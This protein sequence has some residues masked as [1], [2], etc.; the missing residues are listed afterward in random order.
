MNK[1]DLNQFAGGVLL[2]KFNGALETVIKNMQDPN[3]SFKNKRGI[4]IDIG[5]T[6]NEQRDDAKVSIAVKTKL[7][8]VIPI[9]TSLFMGK[10]LETGEI[11]IHEYGKQ[12]PG[13]MNFVDIQKDTTEDQKES[14]V[15]NIKNIRN[16]RSAKTN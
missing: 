5:F 15:E 1:I 4:T 14:N 9:E 3:T 11:E 8:P 13:Q 10:D 2:E 12:V 7:A 16:L 6:Q